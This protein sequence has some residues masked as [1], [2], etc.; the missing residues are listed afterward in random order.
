[1]L[2]IN[3]AYVQL[4][5]AGMATITYVH[6]NLQSAPLL[7]CCEQQ[8]L[9][10]ST[11]LH[12]CTVWPLTPVVLK[13]VSDQMQSSLARAR[14]TMPSRSHIMSACHA[15]SPCSKVSPCEKRPDSCKQTTPVT[16]EHLNKLHF[17]RV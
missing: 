16:T 2:D 14:S 15:S 8:H 4:C 1:M 7:V 17:M 11:A 12:I 13:V 9:V 10:P 3:F 6:G 5:V